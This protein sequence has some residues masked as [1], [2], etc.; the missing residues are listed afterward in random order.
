MTRRFLLWLLLP[1]YP[2]T[3]IERLNR[4]AVLYN[5][6]VEKLK[7]NLVDVPLWDEVIKAA[8]RLK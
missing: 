2:P 5:R 8:S 7:E 1:S 6:Y 3:D 4:F